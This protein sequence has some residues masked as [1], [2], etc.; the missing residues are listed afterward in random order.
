[1]PLAVRY[2]PSLL[3]VAAGILVAFI[4]EA[5]GVQPQAL[6]LAFV[7][8]VAVAAAFLG[9]GPAILSTVASVASFDFL[10]TQPL[11]SLRVASRSDI[12]EMVLLAIV[13]TVVSTV[14]AESRRRALDSQEAAARS[15]ALRDLAHAVIHG[16]AD[17]MLFQKAAEVVARV[18]KAPAVVYA[19]AGG[20]VSVL[21]TAG[22]ASP[23]L[24]DQEAAQ[25][26]TAHGSPTRGDTYP[27]DKA[28]FDMWPVTP[29]GDTR[30]VIGVNF[31]SAEDGRPSDPAKPIE[32]VA[33]YLTAALAR[34]S[35][36]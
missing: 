7:V 34:R 26:A 29:V 20:G 6:A 8:P 23:S 5:S 9:W 13:A 30:L 16:D 24:D 28:Q 36:A 19:A 3:L 32:L 17:A 31:T 10:F 1:M 14:A 35:T 12:A 2:A 15:D 33:G 25:W 18:F 22:G 11:Y 27:F 4:G 21:A